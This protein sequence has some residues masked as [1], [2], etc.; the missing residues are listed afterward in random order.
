MHLSLE[1]VKE[2]VYNIIRRDTNLLKGGFIL[3]V[4][5]W[6]IVFVL[7]VIAELATIQLISIWFAV[8]ALVTLIFTCFFESSLLDQLGVFILASGIFLL[9]T[10][11]YLRRRRNKGHIST[12]I[13]LY[14]GKTAT[15]IEEINQDNGT[16]RVTLSGVDWSAAALSG[17]EIIPAGSIVRVEKVQ[18]AKLIVSLKLKSETEV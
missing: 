1:K 12:N 8:G 14:I 6:A 11:P 4:F 7:F 13:G 5:V 9:I 16:G 3:E 17:D 2:M 15:V 10:F 18:G